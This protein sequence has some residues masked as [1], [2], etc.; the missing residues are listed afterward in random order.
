MTNHLWLD[1]NLCEDLAVVDS[2]NGSGHLGNNNH[3]SQ[4]GL[5][6]VGLLVDGA[7]LLLL[8]ELLDQGHWL[9]L[10]SSCELAPEIE[11]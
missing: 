4:M 8:A 7:F 2:D 3:V 9:A 10:Q 11:N 1:F 5:D 6:N